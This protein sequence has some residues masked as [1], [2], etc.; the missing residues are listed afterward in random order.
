MATVRDT[1]T[2]EIK[3]SN[4]STLNLIPN[5]ISTLQYAEKYTTSNKYGDFKY[6]TTNKYG[7]TTIS[8]LGQKMPSINTKEI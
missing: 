8:S 6:G 3:P 5:S 2:R 1:S 4:V 7:A